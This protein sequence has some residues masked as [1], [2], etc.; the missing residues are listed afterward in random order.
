MAGP[1]FGQSDGVLGEAMEL[2]DEETVL[3]AVS[4][5]GFAPYHRSFNLND[6][7]L[8]NG[9]LALRPGLDPG[10]VGYLGGI[11]WRNTVAYG[12]G[13]NG[14]YLN[15]RGRERHGV[16]AS[17]VER[18]DLL[19]ELVEGLAT[20]IDPETGERPLKRVYRADIVYSASHRDIAPDIVLGYRRGWRGS[21][22]SALGRIV[23]SVF[24]DNL[25]KW[26]GDHCMAA[27]EVPGIL[28]S[29]RGIGVDDPNLQ[30]MAP[31]FL[32]LFGLTPA[33]AMTGRDILA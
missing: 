8:E 11:D 17:G 18:E 29:S 10:A 20:V 32:R 14:L 1:A 16:V 25:K 12:L 7:L 24:S 9:Y 22:E 3:F 21:N 6:W 15:L 27:E 30:D 4:D 2:L 31:T 19:E 33:P 13:I 23:G 26:S 5:H 28:L